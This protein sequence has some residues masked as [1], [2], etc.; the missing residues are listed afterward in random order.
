M[1]ITREK[2]CSR[3]HHRVTA[4]LDVEIDGMSYRAVDWSLGGFRL[5]TVL[6][7]DTAPGKRVSCGVTVP[8]QGF[9]IRFDVDATVVWISV[10]RQ[11]IGFQFDGLGGREK[12][13]LSHFLEELV[14]GSMTPIGDTILRIDTP[15]TP[16]STRPDPNPATEV[17]VRR[18]PIKTMAMTLLYFSLGAVLVGYI[19]LATYANFFSL[20]VESGVVSA[21]IERLVATTDGRIQSVRVAIGAKVNKDTPLIVVEDAKI[22]E[23]IALAQIRIERVRAELA[24]NETQ[25]S[26]EREKLVD[27]KSLAMK[28]VA[29]AGARVQSLEKQCRFAHTQVAR[30][31]KLMNRGYITRRQLDEALS[32]LAALDGDLNSARI[33]L[34]GRRDMLAAVQRGRFYTGDRFEG[35]T[36]ELE[37]EVD[38]FKREV[39]LAT[40]ELLALYEHRQRL[41]LRAPTDGRL[42]EMLKSEGS[43]AKR[44]EAIALFERDEHRLVDVFLTQN[45][46]LEV[47]IDTPARVYFPSKDVVV[48]AMVVSIDRTTS[49][50]DE[51]DSRYN[52]RGPKDRTAVASLRITGIDANQVRDRF[53]PGLPAIVVFRGLATGLAGELLRLMRTQTR[54]VSETGDRISYNTDGHRD[55]S[56]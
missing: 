43:T 28:A 2:P 12:E 22:E 10:E 53:T 37:A 54:A 16:V 38:R 45:E 3:R 23:H 14:R 52:W 42:L 6:S 48:D 27:Y 41:V 5:G 50:L 46:A 44:G 35:E 7:D 25:L 24:T 18:W 49:Y 9:N 1:K 30:L 32:K 8:F 31:E 11:E 15:V 19:G 34:R 21:P 51:V 36:K 55:V 20:E 29:N 33:E 47:K 40:Q 13:L 56:L 39:T 26:V 17:P 4:P